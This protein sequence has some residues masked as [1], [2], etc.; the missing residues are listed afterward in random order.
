MISARESA[1]SLVAKAFRWREKG[2]WLVILCVNPSALLEKI[3]MTTLFHRYIACM[4]IVVFP[5][6]A[7][8]Y[9]FCL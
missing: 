3:M 8:Q 9:V 7:R 5:D 6:L 4:Y 1:A 2:V